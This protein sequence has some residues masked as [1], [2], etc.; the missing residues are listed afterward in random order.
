MPLCSQVASFVNNI[1]FTGAEF[2][3]FTIHA[4]S[5]RRDSLQ[6]LNTPIIS[7]QT[8]SA[9]EDRHGIVSIDCGNEVRCLIP[10][11]THPLWQRHRSRYAGY[12]GGSSSSSLHEEAG[13]ATRMGGRVLH[14]FVFYATWMLLMG[15]ILYPYAM[16][17]YLSW[18]QLVQ[19]QKHHHEQMQ[20]LGRLE[21][22]SHSSA[23]WLLLLACVATVA[24]TWRKMPFFLRTNGWRL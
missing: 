10:M 9:L 22:A 16:I 3:R 14:A 18:K 8:L 21:D 12:R 15:V 11:Q 19:Q 4:R 2:V 6:L 23:A 1:I 24:H 13:E 20:M 5:F 7:L 17:V